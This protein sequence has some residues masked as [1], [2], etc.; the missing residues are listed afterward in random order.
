MLT[1]NG[2]KLLEEATGIKGLQE[3]VESENQQ[4]ITLKKTKHFSEQDYDALYNNLT[5]NI[6]PSKYAEAKKAGEEMAVKEIR[7]LKGYEFEGK[8]VQALTDYL[9]RQIELKSKTDTTEIEKQYQNDLEQMRKKLSEKDSMIEQVTL[10][11]KQDKINAA[12]DNHFNSLRIDAPTHLKEEEQINAYVKKE[13]EKNKIFFKSQYQF[14]VDEN[15]NLIPK[16]T[17]GEVIKDEALRP[18]QIGELVNRFVA[19]NFVPIAQ[20]KAGR[21]EGDVYPVNSNLRNLKSVEELVDYAKSKN[22]KPNSSEMDALYAEF[23]KIN[24]K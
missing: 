16:N 15:G 13:I 1:E 6:D 2:Y 23:A 18:V 20:P 4:E 21:G 17:N 22:I 11:R 14:D 7:K 5:N 24:N 9:E 3:I 10:Q 8:T 19:E 12:I